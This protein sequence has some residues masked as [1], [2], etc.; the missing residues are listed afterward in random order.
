MEVAQS[1]PSDT[2]VTQDSHSPLR[3]PYLTTGIIQSA[4]LHSCRF[5]EEFI[6]CYPVCFPVAITFLDNL[7]MQICVHTQKCLRVPRMLVGDFFTNPSP[8]PQE[9]FSPTLWFL[10]K[11]QLFGACA[12]ASLADDEQNV[13]QAGH[14]TQ[15]YLA[16]PK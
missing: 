15:Q 3:A 8:P 7:G 16:Y 13:A 2:Q 12:C 5:Y 6:L 9:T 1:C 10:A 11:V 4:A 14:G